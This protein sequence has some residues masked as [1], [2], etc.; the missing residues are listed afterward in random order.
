MAIV[1]VLRRPHLALLWSSQVLSALGDYFYAIAVIWIAVQVAGSA[2]GVVAAAENACWFIFGLLGGVYADRWNRRTTMIA[3]DAIRALAVLSLPVLAQLGRLQLWYLTLVA[4]LVGGLGAFFDPALQASLPTL[5]P[6]RSVLQ[7]TNALMDMTRRLARAVGPS[8]AGLLVLFLPLTQF[9]TLDSASFVISAGSILLL[10]SRYRW[11]PERQQAA[12]PGVRGVIAEIADAG[13]LVW[14]QGAV[15]WAYVASAIVNLAWQVAFTLGTALFAAR[16]LRG[17]VG[18]YGLIVGAYGVGNVASNLVVGNVRVRRPFS[19][20][21]RGKLVLA[22]GF[23][24]LAAAP[25][26]WVA[27]VGAALAAL[28]G[29]MGDIPLITV[30]QTRFP[31]AQLGKI[32]SINATLGDLG[33]VVGSLLAVPLYALLGVRAVIAGSAAVYAAVGLAGLLWLLSHERQVALAT[34]P[35]L[36]GSAAAGGVSTGEQPAALETRPPFDAE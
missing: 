10:G 16:V 26:L 17:S 8:L 35:P 23:L 7:A 2:A 13:R 1:R 25:T 5:A 20:F 18:A 12:P 28:G 34:E 6:E 3:A 21:Y 9:F 31:S 22:A 30:V 27:M 15:G 4:M 33:A 32:Y 24:V 11:I 36:A 29:P 19:S 14:H